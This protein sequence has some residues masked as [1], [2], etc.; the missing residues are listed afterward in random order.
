M[1]ILT[2]ESTCDETA[3]AI[4]DEQR[5]VLGSTVASQEEL[6]QK[7][8]GVVPEI[9]ARAHLERILPVIHETLAK[10]NVELKD[11]SAIGVATTPGTA[12]RAS[13]REDT[14]VVT[15]PTTDRHQSL[16]RPRLCLPICQGRNDLPVR[17]LHRQRR[18][19]PSL[20][21]QGSVFIRIHGG[22]DR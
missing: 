9:A 10:A 4:I 18:P 11:L 13:C 2:L 3:A 5:G 7:F 19:Q 8:N 17:R 6:H 21:V 16:A 15:E 14:F 1:L 22:N 12:G 20:R